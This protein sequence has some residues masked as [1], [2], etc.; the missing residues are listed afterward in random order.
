[1]EEKL[2]EY[3]RGQYAEYYEDG[4]VAKVKVL[5]NLC[6]EESLRYKLE[7]VEIVKNQLPRLW[8]LQPGDSFICDKVRH[9]PTFL[10]W[11]LYNIREL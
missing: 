9:A 6:D 2:K 11:E 4:V 10:V 8:S 7:I 3:Q 5:E 1:M